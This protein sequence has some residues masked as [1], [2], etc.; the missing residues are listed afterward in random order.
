VIEIIYSRD[1]M[2]LESDLAVVSP[3]S[4]GI[5]V[6]ELSELLRFDP[7]DHAKDIEQ[8]IKTSHRF[9]MAAKASACTMLQVP[10][11]RSL[12]SNDGSGLVLVDANLD[13]RTM[14]KVSPVSYFCAMLASIFSYLEGAIS[15]SFFCGKHLEDEKRIWG[16]RALMHSLLGQTVAQ[17][18]SGLRGLRGL[19]YVNAHKF[20]EDLEA[21]RVDALCEAFRQTIGGLPRDMM[22]FCLVDGISWYDDERWREEME[23]IWQTLLS[24]SSEEHGGARIKVLLTCPGRSRGMMGWLGPERYV[25]WRKKGASSGATSDRH[26]E[27]Q[28][29]EAMRQGRPASMSGDKW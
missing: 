1:K 20:R 17:L 23:Y 14:G 22:V 11:I 19:G 24:V 3:H 13:T 9:D 27:R 10:E 28:V 4:S 8:I 26:F 12:L 21:L 2:K 6:E 15:I 29:M 16:P 25:D 7:A 18:P 5:D